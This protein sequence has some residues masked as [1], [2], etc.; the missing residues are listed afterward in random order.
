MFYP[1]FPKK[2]SPN[3]DFV[4]DYKIGNVIILQIDKDNCKI[5]EKYDSI[6]DRSN[7]KNIILQLNA[8]LQLVLLLGYIVFNG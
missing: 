4:D 3:I 2:F 7:D 1:G 8:C 6:Q 5:L